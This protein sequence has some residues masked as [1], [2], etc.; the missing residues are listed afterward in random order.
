M[1]AT[2]EAGALGGLSANN[3]GAAAGGAMA[4]YITNSLKKRPRPMTRRAIRK[5]MSWPILW[6]MLLQAQCW[7]RFRA[8][9][10]LQV[11]FEKSKLC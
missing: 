8:T 2:V 10:L 3:L 5:Q 4:P 1:V 9:A 11:P 7:H 6:P